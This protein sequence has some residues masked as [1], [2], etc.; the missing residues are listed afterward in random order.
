MPRKNWHQIDGKWVMSR[1]IPFTETEKASND[2]G[3][4][5][6]K[7]LLS[8]KINDKSYNLGEQKDA[9]KDDSHE[10]NTQTRVLKRWSNVS[11]K[12]VDSSK[13]KKTSQTSNRSKFDLILKNLQQKKLDKDI[14][15]NDMYT[16]NKKREKVRHCS[17]E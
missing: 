7:L 13:P 1:S 10:D 8:K 17:F 6:R 3:S 12:I 9:S 15:N 16:D 2:Y 11:N 5:D 14:N 4:L